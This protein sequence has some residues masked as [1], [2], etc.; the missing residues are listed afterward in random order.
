[1]G[2][3]KSTIGKMLANELGMDFIDSD[4]AIEKSCGLKVSE[5]FTLRG[6]SVF[7]DLEREFVIRGHPSMGIVVACG[8]GLCV[9]SGMM[10][11]LKK[12]G[13]VI[14]LWAAPHTLVERTKGDDSRPLLQT[15]S[16]MKVLEDLLRQRESRYRLADHLIETDLISP[17]ETVQRILSEL[18]PDAS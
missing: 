8:G 7:R 6:E 18:S 14:C 9:P 1:M 2:T 11:E 4:Q 13:K 5:I 15:N 10:E 16:P 12:R 17:R 3:G